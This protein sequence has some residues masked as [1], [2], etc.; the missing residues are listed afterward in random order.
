M[1]DLTNKTQIDFIKKTLAKINTNEYIDD[2]N[3]TVKTIKDISSLSSRK[4]KNKSLES[5]KVDLLK[6]SNELL[7]SIDFN[8]LNNFSKISQDVIS[9][10]KE[11]YAD[12]AFLAI[13]LN[14]LRGLA[15]EADMLCGFDVKN[16]ILE[17]ED[18]SVCFSA[19]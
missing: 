1:S 15:Y 12:W 8:E 6:R 3:K 19:A 4:F 5:Y 16:S 18:S 14:A 17:L 13:E 7:S 11:K 9:E 10:N 2:S